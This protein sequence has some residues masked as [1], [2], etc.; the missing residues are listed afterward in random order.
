MLGRGTLY[1]CGRHH[2]NSDT[3]CNDCIGGRIDEARSSTAQEAEL[4][5]QYDELAADNGRMLETIQRLT[6]DLALQASVI[7]RLL[8]VI[9]SARDG[10]E[11]ISSGVQSPSPSTERGADGGLSDVEVSRSQHVRAHR[12]DD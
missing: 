7:E 3:P 8:G 12:L 5:G 11:H 10:L 9:R 4:R 2:W 6:A 1:S